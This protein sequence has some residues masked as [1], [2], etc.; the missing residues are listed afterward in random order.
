MTQLAIIRHGPTQWNA[1]RKLQ[2][3]TDVPLSR[4]GR[5]M[6]RGWRLPDELRDHRWVSSPLSRAL[7]TAR[8]MGAP[9]DIGLEPRL[10]EVGYGDWEGRT[11][12]SI[13]RE[14][15]EDAMNA[16]QARGLDYQPPGG[17]SRREFHDRL[18][19]WLR[20]IAHEGGRVLA[21]AHQGVI[22][23]LAA[24]AHDWDYLGKPPGQLSSLKIRAVA[25][26]FE[27]ADGGKLTIRTLNVP[28]AQSAHAVS[29]DPMVGR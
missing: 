27:V 29:A 12:A 4:E 22:R 19:D 23:A 13:V 3:H 15:G 5:A 20:D 2:G 18:N 14:I 16:L 7:E 9:T 10:R 11:Y 24:I 8:I 1:A 21:F 28:L 26:Y 17:E 25:H 6:V